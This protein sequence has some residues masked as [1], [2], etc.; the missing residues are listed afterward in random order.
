MRVEARQAASTSPRLVGRPRTAAGARSAVPTSLQRDLVSGIH[1]CPLPVTVPAPPPRRRPHRTAATLATRQD[2]RTRAAATTAP[3]PPSPAATLPPPPPPLPPPRP[4]RP[5][6]PA[7]PGPCSCSA[8][9]VCRASVGAERWKWDGGGGRGVR[10]GVVTP[11]PPAPVLSVYPGGA[12]TAVVARRAAMP[13][14]P[15]VLPPPRSAAAAARSIGTPFCRCCCLPVVLPRVPAPLL[16]GGVLLLCG[17]SRAGLTEPCP[18]GSQTPAASERPR[19]GSVA[20]V[21]CRPAGWTAIGRRVCEGGGRRVQRRGKGR[22]GATS[23]E[24]W[25]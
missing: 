17:R 2:G 25:Q 15:A 8:A 22:R 4:P 6:H 3:P 19:A 11:P 1:R 12:G 23:G 5:N 13:R 14:R 21:G 24:A 10:R 18:R 9:P 16:G 20:V 7:P